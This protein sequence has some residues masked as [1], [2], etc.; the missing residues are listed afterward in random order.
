MFLRRKSTDT[1]KDIKNII[2]KKNIISLL[3]SNIKK[4]IL[5]LLFL[6]F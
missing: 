6:N 1:I 4:K 2:K 3:N 5:K